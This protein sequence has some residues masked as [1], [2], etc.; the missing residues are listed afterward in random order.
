MFQ[1]PQNCTCGECTS[2]LDICTLMSA[3]HG[4]CMDHRHSLTAAGRKDLQNLWIKQAS[5]SCSWIIRQFLC[6]KLRLQNYDSVLPVC[7]GFT[8]CLVLF[9]VVF[10]FQPFDVDVPSLF[11]QLRSRLS[12]VRSAGTSPQ[13][14][15]MES[16]PAKAAR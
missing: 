10:C 13:E 8:F 14:S 7:Q 9:V 5:V 12:P 3:G 2:G 15:T 6:T 4:S 1:Q 11:L 16:S